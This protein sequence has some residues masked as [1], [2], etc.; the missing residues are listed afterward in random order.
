MWL[1]GF[2]D[3]GLKVGLEGFRVGFGF[4]VVTLVT[5]SSWGFSVTTLF[6]LET[7]WNVDSFIGSSVTAASVT[8]FSVLTVVSTTADVVNLTSSFDILLSIVDCSSDFV[9]KSIASVLSSTSDFSVT[10]LSI[11]SVVVVVVFLEPNISG[12][13]LLAVWSLSSI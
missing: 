7:V 12:I 6:S 13:L 5:S 8:L 9:S 2:C 11:F 1:Y 4:A 10:V 3:E